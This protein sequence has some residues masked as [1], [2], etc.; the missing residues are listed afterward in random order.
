MITFSIVETYSKLTIFFST[1][2][3]DD[4]HSIL[5]IAYVNPTLVYLSICFWVAQLKLIVYTFLSLALFH[6]VV[7]SYVHTCT[8]VYHS[9]ICK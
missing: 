4:N 9:C 6:F 2:M 7:Q 8:V 1:N 3:I 5:S